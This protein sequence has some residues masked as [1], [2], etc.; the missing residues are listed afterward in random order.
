MTSLLCSLQ[1]LAND[2]VP[3]N[4]GNATSK[5][6]C[7][8]NDKDLRNKVDSA[9]Q[10]AQQKIDHLS[11]QAEADFRHSLPKDACLSDLDQTIRLFFDELCGRAAIL[12]TRI[13]IKKES[14][15]KE[16]AGIRLSF[17]RKLH[18]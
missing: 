18:A 10:C 17:T 15:E 8:I 6:S 3:S 12:L 16:E 4:A 9:I 7:F 1:D 2:P 13:S 5:R 11:P 14:A